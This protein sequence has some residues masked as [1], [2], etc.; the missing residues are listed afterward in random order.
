MGDALGWLF[1]AAAFVPH[2]YCL[3]WRPDLVALYA[4]SDAATA[5]AY[6]SIP[7]AILVFF[8]RRPGPSIFP[9]LAGAVRDLHPG[10]WH[11]PMLPTS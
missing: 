1:G 11:L 7:A 2:G 5:L 3:L 10:L 8:Y 4:T 6:F 9:A